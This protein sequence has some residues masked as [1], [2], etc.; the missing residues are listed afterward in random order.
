MKK[1]ESKITSPEKKL[2]L[3]RDKEIRDFKLIRRKKEIRE[4]QLRDLEVFERKDINF[5]KH[6]LN[7]SNNKVG[8]KRLQLSLR[9]KKIAAIYFQ[10]ALKLVG[11][12]LT[13]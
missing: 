8:S 1:L 7:H 2:G 6:E 3:G 5:K 11:D 9:T 4:K 10:F 13:S 12:Y